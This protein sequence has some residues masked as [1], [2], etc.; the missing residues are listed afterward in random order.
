MMH[1]RVLQLLMDSLRYWVVEM[2][3]DGFRFDLAS[4]LARQLFDVDKL[5]AFFDVIQQDPIISKVKLI[6]E[7]WDIGEGGYQVG[8]FPALWAEW[9]GKYRDT[10][11]RFWTGEA[12]IAEFS[13][14]AFWVAATSIRAAAEAPRQASTSSPPMMVSHWQIWS[15]TTK[16]ITRLMARTTMTVKATTTAGIAVPR[17]IPMTPRF[18]LCG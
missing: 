2:H 14:P 13:P 8:N 4:A 16:S 18:W 17:A 3:V 5:S 6:A 11:R 7:P 12:S 15:V 10:V 1:P 9:N